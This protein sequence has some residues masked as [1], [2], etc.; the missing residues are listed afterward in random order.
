M[1]LLIA[2][3]LT[4]ANIWKISYYHDKLRITRYL[5]SE[6]EPSI[7]SCSLGR[8]PGLFLY[9]QFSI[10][11]IIIWLTYLSIDI[12]TGS[13]ELNSN[14][15]HMARCVLKNGSKRWISRLPWSI[16]HN[17]INII[18][19][20][21]ITTEILTQSSTRSDTFFHVSVIQIITTQVVGL[22]CV[23]TD[24]LTQTTFN[25]FRF[26]FSL[27]KSYSTPK[28]GLQS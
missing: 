16:M 5:S 22:V 4:D 19:I 23:R 13:I 20:N 18:H 10:A 7:T 3:L 21:K 12:C 1:E 24:E 27:C 6:D 15:R 26:L 9:Y 8:Q 11:N 28:F 17:Y 14:W 25:Y 2:T